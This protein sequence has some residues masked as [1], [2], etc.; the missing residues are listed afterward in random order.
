MAGFVSVLVGI[1]YGLAFIIYREARAKRG[2]ESNGE[3]LQGT[4][5]EID[6]GER[7]QTHN[8]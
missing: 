4:D 6:C 2:E 3:E 1:V 5:G 7:R 8:T